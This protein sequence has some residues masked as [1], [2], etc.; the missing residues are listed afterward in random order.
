MLVDVLSWI[1][2]VLGCALCLIGGLGLLRLPDFY[3]RLHGGGMTD[4]LGA[5][6]VLLGPDVSGRVDDGHGEIGDDFGGAAHHQ[7]DFDPRGGQSRVRVGSQAFC[8]GK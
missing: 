6:L 4:T 1:C 7:S 2:L 5:G 3:S 8:E